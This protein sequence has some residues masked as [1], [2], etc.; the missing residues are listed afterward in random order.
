MYL[1][2]TYNKSEEIKGI[3]PDY[4]HRKMFSFTPVTK[5]VGL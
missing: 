1:E 2:N 3:N 4:S 5:Q